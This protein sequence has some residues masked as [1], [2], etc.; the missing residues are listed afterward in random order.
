MEKQNCTSLTRSHHQHVVRFCQQQQQ[1]KRLH[2]PGFVGDRIYPPS[3]P[4]SLDNMLTKLSLKERPK[5]TLVRKQGFLAAINESLGDLRIGSDRCR[6]DNAA[7][8]LL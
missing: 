5:Q 7:K 6:E 2:A 8:L 1:K 4:T 3:V